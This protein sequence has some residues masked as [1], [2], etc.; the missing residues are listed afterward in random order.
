MRIFW[1]ETT[2]LDP[3]RARRPGRRSTPESAFAWSLLEVAA[4]E[5]WDVSLPE[6][7][8]LPGG[9]PFF[10]AYPSLHV[11]LSHTRGVVLAALSEHPVGADAERRRPLRAATAERLFAADR[12]DLELFELWTLR[13]SWF[14][15][16]GAGDLRDIPFSRVDGI[17]SPPEPG[18]RCRVYAEIPGCAAA[19][20]SFADD[21]PERLQFIDPARICT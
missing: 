1:T 7:A 15:L 3:A 11:S 4:R 5:T 13:E 9:K 8:A 17:L 19:A 16:T 14:K 18:A 20:C 2:G 21:P 10:P 12:G 6:A